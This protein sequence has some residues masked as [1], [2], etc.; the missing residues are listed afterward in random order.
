MIMIM[1]VIVIMNMVVNMYVT[2]ILIKIENVY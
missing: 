2:S 1:N